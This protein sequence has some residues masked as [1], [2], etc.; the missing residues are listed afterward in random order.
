M[1]RF[2]YRA[3]T[4]D[5]VSQ[6]GQIDA[7]DEEAAYAELRSRRL[8]VLE[9]DLIREQKNVEDYVARLRRI[10]LQTLVVFTR[11][12]ATMIGA[13]VTIFEALVTLEESEDNPKFREVVSELAVAIEGGSSLSDA[14]RKHPE[15]FNRL[16]VAMVEVGE[17][18]G[19]LEQTLLG[20]AAELERQ[21]RLRRQVRAAMAY[22]LI[23]ALFA[24]LVSMLIIVLIVPRF[25]DLFT[26][27]GAKLP[28]PTVALIN[29]SQ[30]LVPPDKMV[31]ALKPFTFAALL[32]AGIIVGITL[33]QRRTAGIYAVGAGV[34]T[35]LI[36][37]ALAFLTPV[38]Q[39]LIHGGI[40]HSNTF[41]ATLGRVGGVVVFLAGLVYLSRQVIATPAGRDV[42][43]R[44]KLRLPVLGNL[45]RMIAI[46]RFTGSLSTML[47]AGTSVIVAFD[48]VG[49][50][51]ANVVIEETAEEVKNSVIRGTS[52]ALPLA[53]SDVFPPLVVRMVEIGER[54]GT[55]DMMLE[56]LTEFYEDRIDAQ[57]RV[58]ASIIEPIMI[59]VVASLAGTMVI[60]LFL[61]IF[62]LYQQLA[63]QAGAGGG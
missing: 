63:Q 51:A 8:T 34:A 11:Q 41:F 35:T 61:P 26:E 57:I 29:A 44:T 40:L 62:D 52:M 53:E 15:V 43:D 24:F 4:P 12:L 13:G 21:L 49:Q 20:V 39:S 27:Y 9:L 3:L 2:E 6:A 55:L 19:N 30:T 48:I 31:I 1:A 45:L 28:G 47:R 60:L 14:L 38:G 36:G 50:S 42:W 37:C 23:V 16:Y 17:Q 25:A 46:A 5:G 58:L 54:T 33:A 18:S 56:K 22:P 59:V 32:Y 7:P 10:S